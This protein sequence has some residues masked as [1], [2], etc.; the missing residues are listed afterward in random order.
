M[1]QIDI[2]VFQIEKASN[3]LVVQYWAFSDSF[4]RQPSY[5]A[6]GQLAN[7]KSLLS[8]DGPEEKFSAKEQYANQLQ[9]FRGFRTMKK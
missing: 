1:Q 4:R 3:R 9:K 5:I 8:R 7:V 6:Q 2:G